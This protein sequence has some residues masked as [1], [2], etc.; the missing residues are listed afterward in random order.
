MY[1][2]LQA[3]PCS[4]YMD[5]P[6]KVGFI[7]LGEEVCLVDTGGDKDAGKKPCAGR[8]RWAGA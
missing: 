2:L 3:G 6:S 1:E 7:V 4:Y 8:R 5:C